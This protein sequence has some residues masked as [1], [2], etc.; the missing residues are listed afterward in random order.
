MAQDDDDDTTQCSLTVSIGSLEQA[1]GP[2][3]ITE[4]MD[5][6]HTASNVEYYAG[7]VLQKF[8]MRRLI[9]V[10]NDVQSQCFAGD[11]DAAVILD[12]A[13]RELFELSQRGMYKGFISIGRIIRDHFK[14][15]EEQFQSGSHISGLPTQFEELD[16]KYKSFS[17][18]T[19]STEFE[20]LER[21][22]QWAESALEAARRIMPNIRALRMRT[23]TT[24]NAGKR[25]YNY[26]L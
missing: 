19:T 5:R 24:S 1:G 10:S 17:G 18:D 4:I 16:A 6:V 3:Y 11:R 7:I 15:I 21:D 22:Y 23:R 13:E 20:E 2:A 12:E 25:T 26:F 8:I 14:N 9:T